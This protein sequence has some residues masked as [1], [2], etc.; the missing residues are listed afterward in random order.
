MI[1]FKFFRKISHIQDTLQKIYHT[2]LRSHHVTLQHYF[3][4]RMQSIFIRNSE[5]REVLGSRFVGYLKLFSVSTI[6]SMRAV[7]CNVIVSELLKM[8]KSPA[9]NY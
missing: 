4:L 1:A 7:L 2:Y 9:I 3:H 6:N 5:T 8:R